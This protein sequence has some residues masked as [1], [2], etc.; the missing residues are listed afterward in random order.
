M[1]M[2]AMFENIMAGSELEQEENKPLYLRRAINNQQQQQLLQQQ[3]QLQQ[4]QHVS[5][6][7]QQNMNTF[8]H[9]NTIG[10]MIL[11]A[12]NQSLLYSVAQTTTENQECHLEFKA[13]LG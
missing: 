6:Q 5:S 2:F 8:H 10:D 11:A 13:K 1:A 7:Q 12:A 9:P 3:Q 4:Q